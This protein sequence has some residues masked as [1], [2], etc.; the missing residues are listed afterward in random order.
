MDT[1]SWAIWTT[2]TK[3]SL[4]ILDTT[5]QYISCKPRRRKIQAHENLQTAN[6]YNHACE[7]TTFTGEY[8]T[9]RMYDDTVNG[10]PSCNWALERSKY[11]TL[12]N[13]QNAIKTLSSLQMYKTH[14]FWTLR[15]A[16]IPPKKNRLSSVCMYD[17]HMY[18]YMV[19]GS[20]SRNWISGY[21]PHGPFPSV[22]FPLP[23]SFPPPAWL[24]SPTLPSPL[25][26][27]DPIP[28]VCFLPLAPPPPLGR[29]EKAGG[30]GGSSCIP[31]SGKE[32]NVKCQIVSIE[33]SRL[34]HLFYQ[35]VNFNRPIPNL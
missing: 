13:R 28:L 11:K 9:Q 32:E 21:F 22:S 20:P 29:D 27:P 4:N 14:I 35:S 17:K 25:F 6:Y 33:D 31:L 16:R 7:N 18:D 2:I 8:F 26:P 24:S 10:P 30:W 15:G 3:H 34:L 12:H 5:L 23:D 1:A 19:N